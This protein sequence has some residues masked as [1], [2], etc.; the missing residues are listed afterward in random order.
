MDN[1]LVKALEASLL[2]EGGFSFANGWWMVRTYC[3]TMEEITDFMG[4]KGNDARIED[5]PR[6]LCQEEF[7][8]RYFGKSRW[9]CVQD[10]L[11]RILEGRYG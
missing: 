2:K 8:T 5:I 7:G 3:F 10:I 6:A 1:E 11:T 9:A 4:G